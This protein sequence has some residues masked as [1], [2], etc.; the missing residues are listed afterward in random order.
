MVLYEW[1]I[2]S[3]S[4]SLLVIFLT[5]YVMNKILNIEDCST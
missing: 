5:V 3:L 4:T 2:E 1:F